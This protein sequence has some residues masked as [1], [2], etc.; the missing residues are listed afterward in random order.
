MGE[1]NQAMIL[2]YVKEKIVLSVYS[3]CSVSSCILFVIPLLLLHATTEP[4][5]VVFSGDW[6][7]S[8]I[9]LTLTNI[10]GA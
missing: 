3:K 4:P 5:F 7:I 1:E 2:N 8:T 9:T 6:S 10:L